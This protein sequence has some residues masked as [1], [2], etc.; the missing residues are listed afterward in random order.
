MEWRGKRSRWTVTTR[1]CLAAEILIRSTEYLE[2]GLGLAA[3]L[4]GT[5]L[6]TIEDSVLP[7]SEEEAASNLIKL[8]STCKF[9]LFEYFHTDKA[10]H[11]QSF[12]KAEARLAALD[13]FF[14][15]L[16]DAIDVSETLLLVTSDHGNIE[17][18]STKSH[19]FNPVPFVALGL[20]ANHFESVTDLSQIVDRI[21]SWYDV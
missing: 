21:E 10:G 16:L 8:A 1:C 19:T 5:G 15:A 4:T 20:D 6:K 7:I 2:N 9:T 12:K 3:D 17:D 14:A 13:R 11:A 18:L